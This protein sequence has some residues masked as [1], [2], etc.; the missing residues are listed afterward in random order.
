VSSND[1]LIKYTW[2]GDANLDGVVNSTD[3]SAMASTGTTWQTG[4]FNYD[5][6]VNGDD[7]A[8]FMLGNVS[9]KG[10]NISTTLPEP[11]LLLASSLW[12]FAC[13][14]RRCR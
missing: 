11:S 10:A 2:L 3:L 13:S 4:D 14:R 7:Y 5:G 12:L 1:V 8:L 9:S 6:K